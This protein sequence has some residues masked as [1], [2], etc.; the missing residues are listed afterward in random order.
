MD[1]GKMDGWDKI[2]KCTAAYNY[3]CMTYYAPNQIPNM[4]TLANQFAVS[5]RTF[6]MADSPSWG[7]H[8]YAVAAS[9][10]GFLGEIPAPA[11]GVTPGPGWGCNSSKISPWISP[12]GQR[13][14]E[15]SCIPDPAL[16]LPNGGAFESTPVA[17]VPT[18]MDRL[19]SANLSWRLYAGLSSGASGGWTV[20]PSFAECL[21]TNQRNNVV[22]SANVLQDAAAGNLPN[23]SVVIPSFNSGAVSQH[24]G[25]SMVQGDNWIGQIVSAIS[26]GADWSSTA[27][28]IAYDDCGCFYDHVPPPR[29][30]DGTKEGPRIPLVIV[31]PWARPAYT[32]SSPAS[33][34]S[35]LAFTEHTF[36]LAPLS[37]NDASAYDFSNSFNFAQMTNLKPVSM[38][39]TPVPAGE[40]L[41]PIDPNDPS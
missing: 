10:D 17:Y 27:I 33:F 37:A 36:G 14:Q 6:S 23:F 19:D 38:V 16:G 18:I 25:Y 15:P 11:P 9:Q 1:G 26:S 20:C 31:S 13:L 41:I 39:A 5:D 28:F 8:L 34:A 3:A 21:D 24:N 22:P 2:A 35:I 40:K 12:T 29:N 4:V 32:D 7:G 30:P